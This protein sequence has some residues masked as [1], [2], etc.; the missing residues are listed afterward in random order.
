VNPLTALYQRFFAGTLKEKVNCLTLRRASLF[1]LKPASDLT[2]PPIH[3]P[4]ADDAQ[5]GFPRPLAV[6]NTKRRAVVI[7]EIKLCQITVQVF[8]EQC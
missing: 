5:K 4:L 8:S 3:Q 2:R 1:T 7:A 6:L